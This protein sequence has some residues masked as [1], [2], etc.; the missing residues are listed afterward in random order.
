MKDSKNN[1]RY[2]DYKIEYKYNPF[3]LISEKYYYLT[4]NVF[5]KIIYTYDENQSLI[6]WEKLNSQDK[7][8]FVT[9]YDY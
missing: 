6:R 4:E 2:F 5:E 8:V 1:K 7:A 9:T 3:N